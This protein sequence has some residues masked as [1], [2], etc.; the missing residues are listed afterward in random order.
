MP[1]HKCKNWKPGLGT[2]KYAH[3]K[4]DGIWIEAKGGRVFTSTPTDITDKVRDCW[5]Y[6]SL[7]LWSYDDVIAGELYVPDQPASAVSTA[8]A[9]RQEWLEL[10]VFAVLS[11]AGEEKLEAIEEECDRRELWFALYT[12][13][14]KEYQVGD[15]YLDTATVLGLEDGREGIVY[16]NGNLLDWTKWKPIR[17]VDCV[18]TDYELG[19]GKYLGMVG[20]LEVSVEGRV[21]ANVSGMDDDIRESLGEDSIGRVV[22]VAYQYVG[23]R[24]R[25]RHPRFVRFRDDKLPEECTLDQ[26]M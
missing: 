20:S 2:F 12:A 25:L 1:K 14:D 16:K 22:E 19:N 9:E 26:L 11:W 24:G 3:A 7:S 5:W 6:R 13:S 18:V 4:Y 10:N 8:L 21:I 23:S 15:P 17:T